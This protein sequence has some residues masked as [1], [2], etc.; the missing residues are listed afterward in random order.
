LFPTASLATQFVARARAASHLEEYGGDVD[1]GD[2]ERQA[3]L[4][5]E[6]CGNTLHPH[7]S[8]YRFPVPFSACPS[9]LVHIVVWLMCTVD[10][11]F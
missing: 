8:P 2:A 9:L 10:N 3:L 6:R 7:D 5:K 1:D 11:Q 4:V